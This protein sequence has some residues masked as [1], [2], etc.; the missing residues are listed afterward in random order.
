[1]IFFVNQLSGFYV[2]GAVIINGLAMK[3]PDPA[4]NHML[5]VNTRNTRTRSEIC[6]KLTTKTPERSH[7][8][9]SNVFIINFE[10]I[11]HLVLVFI[12]LTLSR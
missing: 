12:W 10:H 3:I 11:S 5:K 6:R 8:R 2:K 9:R 7:C 1:M 4:V